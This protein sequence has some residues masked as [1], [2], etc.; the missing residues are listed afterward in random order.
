[1]KEVFQSYDTII[2]ER[3]IWDDE[4]NQLTRITLDRD[5]WNYSVTT[6]K[7]RNQFLNETRK[8]TE[9]KINNGTYKLA[10]LNN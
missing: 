4:I 1:M 9:D 8:E 6:S 5:A 2:A 10:N 7:Y 3:I